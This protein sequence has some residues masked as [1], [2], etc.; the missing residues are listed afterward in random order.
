MDRIVVD[1]ALDRR[2]L[3]PE[4]G[5]RFL[6]LTLR[7]P[8]APQGLAGRERKPLD[9]AFV[10]DHSGSM[11]GEKLRLV[12]E[13]VAFGI[14]QLAPEDRAAVVIYDH[15]VQTLAPLAPMTGAAK[16]SLTLALGGVQEGGSTAL[17]EGWLTGCRMIADG[18]TP[19]GGRLTRSLL[20]TDGLANVGV[21]DPAELTGHAVELRRR[22]VTTSTFGVGADFDERLLNGLA[23][24]GGGNFHFIEHGQQIPDFFA[25]ELGE[26]LTVVVEGTTV[27]LT[28]PPGVGAEPLNDYPVVRNQSEGAWPD[29]DSG[30]PGGT[31]VTVEVGSLS[32]GEEKILLFELTAPPAAPGTALP[33]RATVRYRRSADGVEETSGARA[34]SLRVATRAEADAEEADAGVIA[35]AGRLQA[36]RAKYEAWEHAQAGRHDAAQRVLAGAAQAFAAPAMAPAA[37]ALAADAAELQRLAE[38]ARD[39][40]DS[41]T[42]KAALYSSRVLRKNQRDYGKER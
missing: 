25:G 31:T 42:S 22:G 1:S 10:L 9:L 12:K 5:R 17:G 36:A 13:A 23:E 34:L 27:A 41:V 11:A 24:A 32:A 35:V 37:P 6:R 2:L 20:L 38:R 21:T 16:A 4:G 7:A 30:A 19:G 40:W 8:Q 26:L 39:G 3:P 28:L 15:T 14:G 29:L 18:A 33:C